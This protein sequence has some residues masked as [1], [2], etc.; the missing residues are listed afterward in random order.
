MRSIQ[1]YFIIIVLFFNTCNS[2]NA[3]NDSIY[4]VAMNQILLKLDIAE[5][6]YDFQLCK[7]QFERISELKPEEWI[8][9]YYVAYANVMSIFYNP[10]SNKIEAYLDEA[11]KYI[12]EI[13]EI[14]TADLSEIKT[15]I[16][17][18]YMARIVTNPQVNGQK[19]YRDI[20]SALEEAKTINNEN[21]RPICLQMFFEK[22]LPDRKSTR[23]NSSH[24]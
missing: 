22:Q 24:L 7:S 19:Y 3:Q 23:L 21:P 6:E 17:L 9:K 12:E 11:S 18:Y 2:L 1:F 8:V 16:G 14:K 15:L 13:G 4:S 10:K 5:S 20:I